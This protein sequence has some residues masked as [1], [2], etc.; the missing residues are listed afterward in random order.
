[1]AHLQWASKCKMN[2]KN[3]PDKYTQLKN[4]CSE[5]R[6]D[7]TMGRQLILYLNHSEYLMLL[8]HINVFTL[9]YYNINVIHFLWPQ[10]V[11]HFVMLTSLIIKKIVYKGN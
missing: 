4:K 7:L 1:M 5:I 9:E 11:N 3:V 10:F 6:T 2:V 8:L